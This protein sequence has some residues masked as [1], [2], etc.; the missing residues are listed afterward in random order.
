MIR[1]PP[2][3]TRT[4]TLFP[5]TTLFRSPGATAQHAVRRCRCGLHRACP[6]CRAAVRELQRPDRASRVGSTSVNDTAPTGTLTFIPVAGVPEIA[7]GNELAAVLEHTLARQPN[8]TLQN[9]D[10]VVVSQKIVSK[11]EDRYV[12]LDTVEA[13]A[14]ARA[15]IGRA[16]V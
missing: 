13:G 11:A 12:E 2:R 7:P 1:R 6:S 14:E 10:G 9:G 5:Y 15:Q 16:H 3:S 8:P 4:D